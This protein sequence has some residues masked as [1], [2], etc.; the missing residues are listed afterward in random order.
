VCMLWIVYIRGS[1]RTQ[2]SRNGGRGVEHQRCHMLAENIGHEY[3]LLYAYVHLVELYYVLSHVKFRN[4]DT[5]TSRTSKDLTGNKKCAVS[6]RSI[7]VLADPVCILPF[8]P[9]YSSI[10]FANPSSTSPQN[11]LKKIIE[12][13][14]IQRRKNS[15]QKVGLGVFGQNR[16][17]GCLLF[18]LSIARKRRKLRKGEYMLLDYAGKKER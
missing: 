1:C 14:I 2:L 15:R 5:I 7:T 11:A 9:I 8:H 6:Q 3:T 16:K 4:Y 13:R 12:L 17:K 18:T 10:L